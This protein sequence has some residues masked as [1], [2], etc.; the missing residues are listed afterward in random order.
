MQPLIKAH[1]VQ[2]KKRLVAFINK[3]Y[4]QNVQSFR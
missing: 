2:N 1:Y 3:Y 4:V